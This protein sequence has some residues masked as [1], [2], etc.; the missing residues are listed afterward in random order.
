MSS[1]AVLQPERLRQRYQL[2]T[3]VETGC[4]MGVSL[5]LARLCGYTKLIS[6]DIDRRCV[7]ACRQ[8]FPKAGI[9]HADSLTMLGP[10]MSPLQAVMGR[11]LFWLDAHF[12]SYYGHPEPPEHRY[13]LP[14]ELRLIREGK[15]GWQHDVIAMDDL[16]VIRDAAN[17]RYRPGELCAAEEH[18][19]QDVSIADLYEPFAATHELRIIADE[20]GSMMFLPRLD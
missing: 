10:C 7:L 17:P 15:R 19:Y 13:P 8:N 6:C 9:L 20:E 1:I 3:F 18:L 12:P 11:T 5:A 4:Y 2:D 14:E 16:R